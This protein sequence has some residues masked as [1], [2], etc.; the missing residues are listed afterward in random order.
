LFPVENCTSPQND[1]VN[2]ANGGDPELE[3]SSL[4][5]VELYTYNLSVPARRNMNDSHVVNGKKIFISIGCADCH[6]PSFVTAVN[7]RFTNLSHHKI[8]PYTD[9]LLHDMRTELADTRP[10][11]LADGNE[12]RTPPL[13][14][15]GLIE[16]VNHHTYS[17]HD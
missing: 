2:A 4:D 17:L 3:N 11:D 9:L 8:Y 12:W 5:A 15:I 10:D 1:C 16:V 7:T 14:G 6:V 13:W